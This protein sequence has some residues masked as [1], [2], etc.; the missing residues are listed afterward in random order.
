MKNLICI[1]VFATSSLIANANITPD[2]IQSNV[3][4]FSGLKI[5]T[6]PGLDG[7]VLKVIPF[8]ETV[9]I[10]ESDENIE[11]IEWMEGS[12]IKIEHQG[13]EGSVFDGFLSDLPVPT[14]NFELSQ[15]DFDLTYP[16]IAWA[17]YNFDE[18][19]KSDTINRGGDYDKIIQYMERGILLTREDSD[20]SFNTSIVLPDVTISEAYNIVK[21]MLL[22]KAER[23]IYDKK[24][25]YIKGSDDKIEKIKINIDNPVTIKK[26][27]NGDIKISVSAFH[28]GCGL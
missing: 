24:A 18:T 4:A 2:P 17:E 11:T 22:T 7:Q 25:I 8:G 28:T 5:R 1:L 3:L 26:L 15:S 27:K 12:W 19:R 14:F 9:N 13:T 23:N 20:Y 10:I 16:M 6:A 21:S